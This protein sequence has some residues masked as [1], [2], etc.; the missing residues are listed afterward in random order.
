MEM[1]RVAV[2]VGTRPNLV[3]L[4]ALWHALSRR[5]SAFEVRTLHTGQH[6]DPAMFHELL[7]DLDLPRP[8]VSLPPQKG[9]RTEQIARM[10]VALEEALSAN[11]PD[12]VIVVGDVNSTAAGA[13]AAR[14]A[15]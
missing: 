6:H 12:L 15:G 14:V 3:K 5:P 13:L 1:R 11:R 4:A 8:D 9:G 10:L 7:D 2:I